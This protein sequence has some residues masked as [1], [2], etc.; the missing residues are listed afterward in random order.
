VW[1]RAAGRP[2]RDEAASQRDQA[3]ATRDRDAAGRDERAEA[4]LAAAGKYAE[5]TRRL[6]DA[7]SGQPGADQRVARDLLA[8][9]Q[10]ALADAENDR[11]AAAGDR[12][13]AAADRQ[14]AAQD[15]AVEAA[16]RGQAAIERARQ[17]AGLPSISQ[18]RWAEL[19]AH[20][21]AACDRAAA[22]SE[23]AH[24]FGLAAPPQREAL[25]HSELP[26]CGP[27]WARCR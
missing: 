11:R 26:G 2:L 16:H 4:R 22:L 19:Y 20:A 18:E 13:A 9:L 23:Q 15:R 14:S 24:V 8:H 6:L 1:H 12:R 7:A 10:E 25:R 21:Q 27:S 3:S 5:I 17:E